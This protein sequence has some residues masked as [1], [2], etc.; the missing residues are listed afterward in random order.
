MSYL[1]AKSRF[2][3]YVTEADTS[4]VKDAI[5]TTLEQ[6]DGTVITYT[7]TS[8][9]SKVVYECQFTTAWN[10]DFNASYPC[11]RLQYS[12]N[13]GTTWNTITG[14]ETF[15][16]NNSGAADYNWH[17]FL[18]VYTI[19]T[20]SGSRKLRLLGRAFSSATEFTLGRSYRP[21]GA[22]GSGACPIV[23]CYSVM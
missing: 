16:G 22:E 20:W 21:V 23:K 9:A 6:F 10:P 14:T 13:G 1:N 7:P 15:L 3:N 18:V 17:S 2:R 12:D 11:V 8:G 5:S 19:A 4:F